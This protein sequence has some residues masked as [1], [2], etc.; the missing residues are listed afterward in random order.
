MEVVWVTRVT[1]LRCRNLLKLTLL[2]LET[3]SYSTDDFSKLDNDVN[4]E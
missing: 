3:Q 2:A 4:I 1:A